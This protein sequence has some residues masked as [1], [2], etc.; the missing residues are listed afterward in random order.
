MNQSLLRRLVLRVLFSVFREKT[1]ERSKPPV[2]SLQD[3]VM[4]EY[5][6]WQVYWQQQG[7][8]WRTEPEITLKRQKELTQCRTIVPNVEQGI[9]PFKGVKL[10]RADVEWLLATHEHGQGPIKWSDAGQRERMGVDLRGAVLNH[11]DLSR[12]PLARLIGG[13]VLD[14]E[15]TNTTV[16]QKR[17]AG[18]KMEDVNLQDAHLEGAY[19]SYANL[20]R[21][22]LRGVYAEEIFAKGALLDGAALNEARL[23]D[24]HLNETSLKS[25]TLRDARLKGADCR[26]AYLAD[27]D[28]TRTQLEESDLRGITFIDDR[29]IA[30]LLADVQWGN[31]NL[32]IIDWGRVKMLRDEY[33]AHQRE[34][35]GG[36]K[37]NNRRRYLDYFAAV[38]ANRQLAVAL[39]GQG[40]N[41]DASRF[42]YRSQ[43]LQKRARWFQMT[44]SKQ[45][46]MDREHLESPRKRIVYRLQGLGAWLFSWFLFLLA[47]YGYKLGRSFLA[48]LLMIGAFMILYLNL[49]PRLTWYE[50]IIVSMTAF[51]G[52]GFSPSTF[53]PGDPLSIA[54]AVEAFVGLI[55]EVTF[56]ATLTRRFFGQ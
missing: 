50:A 52:R 36:V 45:A 21:A 43:V 37:K 53:S 42:L 19:L 49:D 16:E 1:T 17:D 9:F 29:G 48:Y 6:T 30:P 14:K 5:G 31:I 40:L 56:I 44:Q 13:L 23:Q 41:E 35:Q 47:G 8:L 18:A 28:L 10:D 32:S 20:T 22:S 3:T 25:A 26:D 54:S 38:R 33:E 4:N 27:T 2:L 55:I 24:A 46:L 39:Q 11:A 7:Q 15:A 34:R 12:L 51:H